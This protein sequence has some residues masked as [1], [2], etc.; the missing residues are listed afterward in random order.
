MN[1]FRNNRGRAIWGKQTM[2]IHRQTLRTK[3][4]DFLLEER[5]K[6][7]RVALNKSSLEK[8]KSFKLWQVLIGFKRWLVYFCWGR[9]GS[10][11]FF[12]K[13]G[14]EGHLGGSIG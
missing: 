8:D 5:R 7:G 4:R 6:L 13:A 2:V 11:F 12:L 14:D 1:L 10:S 3:E 9:E